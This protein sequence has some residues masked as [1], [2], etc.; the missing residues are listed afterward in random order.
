MRC[1]SNKF[2]P[3]WRHITYTVLRCR[4]T[5]LNSTYVIFFMWLMK[6][7]WP[8]SHCSLLWWYFKTSSSASYLDPSLSPD[9]W[10]NYWASDLDPSCLKGKSD[11]HEILSR[12]ELT[13]SAPMLPKSEI[14]KLAVPEHFLPY[15]RGIRK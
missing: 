15:K 3:E 12:G 13:L 9:P 10:L 5:Q 14:A 2:F 1:G 8:L 11:K 7:C 4:K 6:I